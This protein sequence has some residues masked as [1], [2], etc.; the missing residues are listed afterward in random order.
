[1]AL[2]I[3]KSPQLL[4]FKFLCGLQVKVV[5]VR[6]TNCSPLRAVAFRT[7]AISTLCRM[8]SVSSCS[9]D[10]YTEPLNNIKL[11]TFC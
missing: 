9:V 6:V 10:L 7:S 2:C 3:Q 11:P 8:S 4:I 1:M 5:S